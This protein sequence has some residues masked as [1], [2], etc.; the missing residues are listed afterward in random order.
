MFQSS[1]HHSAGHESGSS[2]PATSSSVQPGDITR[3]S[4]VVQPGDVTRPGDAQ[5]SSAPAH[6]SAAVSRP[7]NDL[8][9]APQQ[10]DSLD[11]EADPLL[12][13]ERNA[14]ST[15]QAV[16]YFVAVLLI[17]ILVA[18]IIALISRSSGGVYCTTDEGTWLCSDAWRIAFGLVPALI[19]LFSLFGAAFLCYQKWKSFQRWRAW[20]GVTILLIPYTMSWVTTTGSLYL[21]H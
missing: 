1:D 21:Q 12:R 13:L 18:F 9:S 6:L 19:S 3:P 10:Y 8:D 7:A 14:R 20:L 2:E 4:D 17:P 16:I 5:P 11:Y 15:R